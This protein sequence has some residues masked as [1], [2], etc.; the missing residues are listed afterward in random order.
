[1]WSG[2][3]TVVLIPSGL[4][5]PLRG[6]GGEGGDETPG[7]FVYRGLYN[8][9]AES[10]VPPTIKVLLIFITAVMNLFQLVSW[11]STYFLNV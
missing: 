11:V 4:F 1:M 7:S 8:G 6:G 9:N 5:R 10:R 3:R 2:S